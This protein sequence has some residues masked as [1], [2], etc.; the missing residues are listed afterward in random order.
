M[1]KEITVDEGELLRAM[2]NIYWLGHDLLWALTINPVDGL[3]KAK[4]YLDA[5]PRLGQQISPRQGK[6]FSILL[7]EL[8]DKTMSARVSGQS[9][10]D[11]ASEFGE[12]IVRIKNELINH[13][14]HILVLK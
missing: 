14:K 10:E 7:D 3:T 6:E 9:D 13:A 5:L 8:I 11:I 2:Y 1:T 4:K 12:D